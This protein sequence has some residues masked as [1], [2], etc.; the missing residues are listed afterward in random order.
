M[1]PAKSWP[2]VQFSHCTFRSLSVCRVHTQLL[3]LLIASAA[4]LLMFVQLSGAKAA[5]R[6]KLLLSHME[7]TLL[8]VVVRPLY[9][10]VCVVRGLR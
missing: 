9:V 1:Q 4:D 3:L 6:F 5:A 2:K 10:F 7:P 8:C